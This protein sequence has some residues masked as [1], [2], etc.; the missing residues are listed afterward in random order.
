MEMT[1]SVN[2]NDFLLSPS[3]FYKYAC[4]YFS[5]F[6]L[7]DPVFG[8]WGNS[9]IIGSH[10]M[11][12]LYIV[13]L[14]QFIWLSRESPQEMQ[15]IRCGAAPTKISSKP[16]LLPELLWW[17]IMST[18]TKSRALFSFCGRRNKISCGTRSSAPAFLTWVMVNAMNWPFTPQLWIARRKFRVRE[19]ACRE[20]TWRQM[21]QCSGGE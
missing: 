6:F 15:S 1:G 4:P 18:G 8:N 17:R 9:E 14:V 7:V 10:Q 2:W 5:F 20:C 3:P 12:L 21:L 11:V 19:N 16:C 13:C